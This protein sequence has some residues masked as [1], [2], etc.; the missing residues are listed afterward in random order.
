MFLH[1]VLLQANFIAEDK[2]L[3][4]MGEKMKIEKKY[5]SIILDKSI[6]LS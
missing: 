1:K 3:R 6:I 2:Y 4:K 5:F